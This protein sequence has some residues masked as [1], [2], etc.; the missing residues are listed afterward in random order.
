[1]VARTLP[2]GIILL[3]TTCFFTLQVIIY[4]GLI[5]KVIKNIRPLL[6]ENY[7][8]LEGKKLKWVVFLLV[9]LALMYLFYVVIE[10]FT[11]LTFD[12]YDLIYYCFSLL[13]IMSVI[14]GVFRQNE[15]FY[16]LLI[17]QYQ[18]DKLSVEM[19]TAIK[20]TAEEAGKI[21]KKLKELVATE[22]FYT[23]RDLNPAPA[24]QNA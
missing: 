11:D 4:S 12:Q 17:D 16:L 19:N 21:H 23:Q 13:F 2:G 3:P 22:K 1:M 24:C 9:L 18:E 6:E 8:N 7:S 10:L 20:L 14:Y 5:L 15:H